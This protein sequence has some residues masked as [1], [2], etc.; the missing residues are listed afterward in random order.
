MPVGVLGRRRLHDRALRIELD[1]SQLFMVRANKKG[2]GMG[3]FGMF[4]NCV[5]RMPK[6]GFNLWI[7][8]GQAGNSRNQTGVFFLL[9]ELAQTAL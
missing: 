4:A 8:V 6:D 9:V 5:K 2:T 3:A 7:F 1:L